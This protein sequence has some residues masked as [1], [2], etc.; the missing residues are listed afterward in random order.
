MI[1]NLLSN[2]LK[3]TKRGKVLLG[4]RRHQGMLSIEVWD[5]GIGIPD[6]ELQAIFEE[7]H[8]L[9]NPARERS[10]G[11]G[12]GLSIVQRL[13]S[14]LGHRIRVRSRPDR[15]S[16]FTVEVTLPS[17][18]P[19]PQ[20][21]SHRLGLR[22]GTIAG[23]HGTG[24]ILVIE[25]DPEVREL[26]ELFLKDEGHRTATAPDGI[27]ALDLVAG[28]TVQ[29][30]LILADYNLPNGMDGLQVIA[31]LRD[32]LHR[33]IPAIILTGD[34]STDALHG[35]ALQNCVQLNK[36]VKLQELTQAIQRLLPIAHA[37]ASPHARRIAE[38]SGGPRAPVIFVVDDDDQIRETVREVLEDEGRLVED[39]ATCEAFLAA[40]RPG[41]EACLVIDAYL[42]GM[43]G[44]QLLQRLR[45]AG[46]DLPAIMITGNSD[47]PM[48]VEAMK[49]G[50]SDFIEK[51]ITRNELLDCVALALE[52]ARDSSKLSARQEDAAQHVA[53]LTSRQR[54]IMDLVLAGQ[55]S[56]NI[57]ADLRISQRT[58]ENHR[59][60]IMKKMGTRSLPA[61]ARLALAAAGNGTD[62]PHARAGTPATAAQQTASR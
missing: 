26:L 37:A 58:V 19:V 14:L 53:G 12:L 8:Q 51:P 43:N 21:E 49:A 20:P 41:R 52:Q 17:R 1:R 45:E 24:A 10:R 13:G 38:A 32:R 57:A 50:A 22:A 9:D 47:V 39:Y 18:G 46:H 60:S 29:P 30:D 4:C 33:A 34:I 5:T 2:A 27:A 56:K 3:Y 31:K 48:A 28:G 15:G 54:Q 44:L 23:A 62:A 16:V 36:P 6:G 7:Y 61:L 40:Y 55:P 11:L 42:P 59:A 25:D 35:I